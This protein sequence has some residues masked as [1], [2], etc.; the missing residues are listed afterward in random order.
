[1]ELPVALVAVGLAAI[2]AVLGYV[3]RV[4][5]RVCARLSRIETVLE[6]KGVKLPQ[7]I[8]PA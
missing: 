1:M 4:L 2:L 8:D 6:T 5:V 3:A 7:L